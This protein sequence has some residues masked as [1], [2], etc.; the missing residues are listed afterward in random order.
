MTPIFHLRKQT[1]RSKVAF[2]CGPTG[3]WCS[4]DSSQ[5]PDGLQNEQSVGMWKGH[6]FGQQISVDSHPSSTQGD[7]NLFFSEPQ[8]PHL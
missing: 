4:W 3:K 8:S 7:L 5:H 1:Q 2:Q 6:P